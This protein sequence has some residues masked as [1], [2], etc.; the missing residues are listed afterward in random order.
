MTNKLIKSANIPD[1]D[2]FYA[3]L[4]EL[5]EDHDKESSDAINAQ[6]ILVLCNHIGNR[7]ILSQAFEL[8]QIGRS[9]SWIT[10]QTEQE[11]Q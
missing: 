6:L 5:H 7:D 2:G 3:E 4:L 8:V 10:K 11:Q 1:P 9:T